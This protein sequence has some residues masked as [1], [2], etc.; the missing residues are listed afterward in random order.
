MPSTAILQSFRQHFGEAPALLVRAPG[1]INLIGEHTDYNEGFV[2]PAAIDRALYFAISPRNDERIEC[3]AADLDDSFSGT[4]ADHTKSAKGWPNYLLGVYSEL[5]QDG[6]RP[7]GINVVLGG[8]I[9]AGAGLSSSAALESGLLFALNELFALGL[10]RPQ[11]ARLAQRAENNFVGLRCGIMDMFTS[12]MGREH[13]AIKLD[14]RS[15]EHTYIPFNDTRYAFVLCDSRVKHTLAS[16]DFNTRRAECEEGVRI[17]KTLYPGIRSLRDVTLEMLLAEKK[18][19]PHLIFDRCHY[20]VKENARLEHACQVLQKGDFG[21]FGNLM[22]ETDRGLDIEYDVS[23]AET[24]YLVAA[25]RKLDYCIGARMMG[26]GFGGCTLNLMPREAVPQFTA[27]MQ[28]EYH[29]FI[30]I[31]LPC[32]E[33]QLTNGVEILPQA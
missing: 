14:C 8:D 5:Q 31:D 6:Y 13:H 3:L 29:D 15:L 18:R 28:A 23:C 11:M 12:L 7:N 33:V 19:L 21:T 16:S 10:S 32:W 30:Q 1:R 2:L 20:V 17:L 4:A 24:R 25:T 26:G 9:P 27:F 22:Y